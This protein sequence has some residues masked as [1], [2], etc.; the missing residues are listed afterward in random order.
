[1]T[2]RLPRCRETT[3][4]TESPGTRLVFYVA[5]AGDGG[6]V[7]L[8]LLALALTHRMSSSNVVARLHDL[9]N[10]GDLSAIPSVYAERFRAHMPAGW[11]LP[12]IEGHAGAGF[13]ISRIRNA[14][15]DWHEEVHDIVEGKDRVVT[16]YTSTGTNSGSL[17]G[18]QPTG[19][20]IAVQEIS[21]YKIE[22]GLVCEQWCLADDI[23]FARQM[24]LL[25]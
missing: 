15:P 3:R 13:L 20:R 25:A 8:V 10:S 4:S 19:R 24:G 21:I 9:W 1:M 2:E 11:D 22:S 23:S 14:F 16:R 7:K 12:R 18:R 17:D 5:N 6:P